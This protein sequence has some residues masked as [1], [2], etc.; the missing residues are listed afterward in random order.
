MKLKR[1]TAAMLAFMMVLGIVSSPDYLNEITS[2]AADTSIALG[3]PTGD[4]KVDS[5]DAT[6]ILSEY[7]LLSTGGTSSLTPE[8]KEAADVKKDG[9]IDSKDAT[10][11]LSYYSYLST[12]GKS[13]ITDLTRDLMF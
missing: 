4:S 9:K 5:K 3:D 2:V 6:F 13:I 7:S 12:G 11:V 8:Q 1:L 10:I